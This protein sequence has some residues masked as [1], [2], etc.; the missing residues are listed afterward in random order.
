[1]QTAAYFI[2]ISSDYRLIVRVLIGDFNYSYPCNPVQ[3][4]ILHLNIDCKE[5][6][7][8]VTLQ[9]SGNRLPQDNANEKE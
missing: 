5:Q 3:K 4:N 2:I 6:G 1:M 8:S 9:W 7:S